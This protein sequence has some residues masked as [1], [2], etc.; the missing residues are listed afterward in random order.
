VQAHPLRIEAGALHH[1]ELTPCTDINAETF[2]T[3]PA[4]HG[5][6]EEGLGGVVD[7][8]ALKGIC[9]S[10]CSLPQ[11]GLIQHIDRCAE[12]VGDIDGTE[13]SHREQA[14]FVLA[15]TGAP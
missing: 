3:H 4:G 12:L 9:E 2:V 11:V 5:R 6:T 1:S 7:V 14:A 13:A 10:A 8:P 15:H